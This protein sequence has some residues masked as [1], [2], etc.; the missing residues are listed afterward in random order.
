MSEKRDLWVPLLVALVGVGLAVFHGLEGRML[1]GAGAAVVGLV[2]AL[3]CLPIR[4]KHGQPRVIQFG[5]G[6]LLILAA[7]IPGA[8]R[9]VADVFA[10]LVAGAALI[11]PIRVA[12]LPT[13]ATLL[14]GALV[15]ALAGM[16]AAIDVVPKSL[17]WLLLAI[18]F[19]LAMQVWYSR[20]REAP[21]QTIGS[22]VCVYGGSFDPFHD[23]HRALCEAAL[24]YNDRLLV[25]VA[26]AAPHKFVGED[27]DEED[28]APLGTPFHHRVAMTRLGTEGLPRTEVLELEGRRSGPSYTVD[29][30]ES[31]VRRFP[32]GTRFRLLLGADMYQDFHTWKDWERI[33]DMVRLL[34]AARPGFE[35]APPPALADRTDEV[36][37][38]EAPEL[39][40]SSTAIR[41]ALGVE[42]EPTGLP[43]NVRAYI[44]DHG[45]Y[46]GRAP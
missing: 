9:G 6:V 38:L 10:W 37:A 15:F 17:L 24:R 22:R 21:Q 39:D 27:A 19:H 33:L 31:L 18:A 26:G 20:P 44:R 28:D 46:S 29:S 5:V 45:L 2:G 12:P 8:T 3:A 1:Q 7:W 41:T 42:E 25:V 30:L 23:G 36:L 35:L 34:V 11:A 13:R 16:L 4:V 14:I 40:V 32:A 43:P